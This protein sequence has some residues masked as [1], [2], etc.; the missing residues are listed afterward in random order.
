MTSQRPDSWKQT[1]VFLRCGER[2]VK[3]WEKERGLPVHRVPGSGRGRVFAY[4]EE[5]TTWL[6]SAQDLVPDSDARAAD[7][8]ELAPGSATPGRP[9][10]GWRVLVG[11]LAMV[12]VSLGLLLRGFPPA[13]RMLIGSAHSKD[14][15]P[16]L[17]S[18]SPQAEE[19]YL[20][21]R[22]YWNKRTP[23]DLNKAVDFFTQAIVLDPS[24]AKAYVG[25]ADC[26]NLL[27]EFSAMP[28]RDAHPRALAAARKAVELD[29]S[30]SEAHTSLAFAT[31]YWKWDAAAAEREFKRAIALDPNNVRAHHWYATSLSAWGRRQEALSQ[32]DLAQKLEPASISILADKGLLLYLAGQVNPALA[33][34]QQLE[35]SEPSYA[36]PHR[37]LADIFFRDGDY[38]R[39]LAERKKLALLLHDDADLAITNAAEK[40]FAA[41]G[42]RSML[43]AMLPVQKQ[44]YAQGAVPATALAA[45]CARLGREEAALQY[46]QV[47]YDR[48]EE[49]LLITKDDPSFQSLRG[50]PQFE[51]LLLRIATPRPD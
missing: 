1:A 28:A 38:P 27:R 8:G 43:A 29:D 2:T 51:S 4:A 44:Y 16:A 5:L 20:Q 14:A 12:L 39:Y 34:L 19:L 47:A 6:Q 50:V 25:L 22:Y 18:P 15:G 21:G 17:H 31:L 23:D 46:L 33:L 35:T 11:L 37:Y 32:I 9:G 45:T 48:R 3:R 7:P 13:G 36:A 10:S 40:G 24:Y 30:S 42:E 41:G 26:Y 49:I